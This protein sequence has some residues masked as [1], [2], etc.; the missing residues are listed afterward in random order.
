MNYFD[1]SSAI[2]KGATIFSLDKSLID[3]NSS[4][5]YTGPNIYGIYLSKNVELNITKSIVESFHLS[6]RNPNKEIDNINNRY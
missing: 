1:N 3:I 5:I 4:F 6:D 2:E